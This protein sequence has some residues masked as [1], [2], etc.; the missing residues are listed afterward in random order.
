MGNRPRKVLYKIDPGIPFIMPLLQKLA[1]LL[2]GSEQSQG[3]GS[4]YRVLKTTTPDQA[5]TRRKKLNTI[6]KPK[7]LSSKAPRIGSCFRKRKV[8]SKF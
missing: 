3:L 5:N 6:L 8:S 2:L 7:A 1:S 4:R